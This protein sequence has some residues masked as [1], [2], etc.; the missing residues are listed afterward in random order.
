MK[1]LKTSGP[2]GE[3]RGWESSSPSD[4]GKREEVKTGRHLAVSAGFCV[5]ISKM[6]FSPRREVKS[7]DFMQVS[8]MPPFSFSRTS[9]KRCGKRG[10]SFGSGDREDSKPLP[11]PVLRR[12]VLLH[13]ILC[14]IRLG[15]LDE[16]E[17][18]QRLDA[19]VHRG[20]DGLRPFQGDEFL[21]AG[22][23]LPDG[24]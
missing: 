15:L 7:L 18:P 5:S 17:I 24:A 14:G 4:A 11:R 21:G 23:C 2:P 9:K 16:E 12:H 3:T 1:A 20:S 8:F 10:G 6:I 22:E 19:P 13:V